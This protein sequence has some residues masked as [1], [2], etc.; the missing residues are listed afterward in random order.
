MKYNK[1]LLGVMSFTF[2]ASIH[3][4]D[5]FVVDESNFKEIFNK[6][7]STHET[8]T[9]KDANILDVELSLSYLSVQKMGLNSKNFGIDYDEDFNSLSAVNLF[10]S[11]DFWHVGKL[12]IAPFGGAGFAYKQSKTTVRTKSGIPL[13]DIITVSAVPLNAGFLVKHPFPGTRR[14]SAFLQPSLGVEWLN[15]SGSLDGINES[16]WIQFYSIRGG[17]VLFENNSLSSSSWFDGVTVSAA[18]LKGINSKTD[19]STW[20]LDLGMNLTL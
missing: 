17:F 1:F 2:A 4:Q 13:K 9:R 18:T 12:S 20:S 10:V 19:H 7:V 5:G 6:N 15:Q 14:F 8:K 3:A 11:K 16:A